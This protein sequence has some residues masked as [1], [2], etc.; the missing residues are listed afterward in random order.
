MCVAAAI[1]LSTLSSYTTGVDR[2]CRSLHF[3][4]GSKSA[5]LCD[6]LSALNV[7]RE[8]PLPQFVESVRYPYLWQRV[9]LMD[10]V[11]VTVHLSVITGCIPFLKPFFD[12]IRSS[13]VDSTVPYIHTSPFSME[14]RKFRTSNKSSTRPLQSTLQSAGLAP[15]VQ[16]TIVGGFAR[17]SGSTTGLIEDGITRERA[18]D[19]AVA[20]RA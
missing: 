8:Q 3:L 1:Q 15:E 14:L 13:L 20:P 16:N 12:S 17:D 10:T 5:I 18:V 11:R 19:V 9:L 4:L 7:G 6:L 2:T